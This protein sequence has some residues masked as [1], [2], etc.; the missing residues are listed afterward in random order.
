MP[1]DFAGACLFK[2]VLNLFKFKL[3]SYKLKTFT[4][5]FASP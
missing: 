4:P 1:R 3:K 2:V 5:I